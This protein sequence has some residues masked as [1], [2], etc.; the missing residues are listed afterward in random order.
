MM[1]SCF[2]HTVS[3]FWGEPDG[4][5][6]MHSASGVMV[7]LDRPL[8]ITAEH[9]IYEFLRQQTDH[10]S[11]RL[12]IAKGSIENVAER[13]IG[14]SEATRPRHIRLDWNGP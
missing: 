13:I 3:V 1:H 11:L 10:P 9:V 6:E 8:L 5:P 12:Q 7:E 4:E 14:K 2:D